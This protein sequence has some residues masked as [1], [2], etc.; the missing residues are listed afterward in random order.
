MEPE[1]ERKKIGEEKE[2]KVAG[3]EGGRGQRERG[4]KKKS[5]ARK[6]G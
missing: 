3:K 4:M 5:D 1:K 2:G 6:G